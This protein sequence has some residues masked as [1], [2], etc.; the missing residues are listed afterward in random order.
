LRSNDENNEPD[1][2]SAAELLELAM[3]NLSPAGRRRADK[4]RG[5]NLRRSDVGTTAAI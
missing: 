1:A 2:R 3:R 5:A 4:R